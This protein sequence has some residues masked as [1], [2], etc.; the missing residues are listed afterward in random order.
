MNDGKE[1]DLIRQWQGK[2]NRAKGQAFEKRLDD[3]FGYYADKGFAN[4][5]KTPEPMRTIKPYG[6]RKFGQFIAVYSKKAQPDYK[7]TLKGGRSIMFEAKYTDSDRMMKN[8]VSKEQT[9]Y[10]DS[11]FALGAR[12]YVIIG[13]TSGEVYRIPW[14][15]WQNMKEIY[16]RKY[17]KETDVQKY[18]IKSAWNTVLMILE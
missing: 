4:I 16:G 9:D 1:K 3:A 7:G 11:H 13:F 18:K 10:M 14:D 5:E 8:R 17:L 12:C 6:D 15:V 2:V